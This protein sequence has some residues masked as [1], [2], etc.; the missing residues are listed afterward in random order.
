LIELKKAVKRRL[1]GAANLAIGGA[2][3]I[4]FDERE[5]FGKSS[6]LDQVR[7]WWRTSDRLDRTVSRLKQLG[8]LK[9][10]AELSIDAVQLLSLGLSS[11]IGS[12]EAFVSR[13]FVN[14][15]CPVAEPPADGAVTGVAEWVRVRAEPT[16]D[17]EE[18]GRLDAGSAVRYFPTSLT[19]GETDGEAWIRLVDSGNRRCGWVAANF[20][21]DDGHT[22]GYIDPEQYVHR[23]LR[24]LEPEAMHATFAVFGGDPETNREPFDDSALFDQLDL[25]AELGRRY[26]DAVVQLDQSYG[27]DAAG[28]PGCA[29]FD[30]LVCQ[31][32]V[33]DSGAVVAI[34]EVAAYGDGVTSLL[35]TEL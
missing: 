10:L 20:V 30:G 32:V 34:V 15:I 27:N 19:D 16:T 6:F 4:R 29:F 18:L 17:S 11:A 9:V 12:D 1:F 33:S 21:K 14:G 31:V 35:V 23:A 28:S 25:L 13:L 2:K 7:R 5:K 8:Q 3:V 26:P 22:V 24:R